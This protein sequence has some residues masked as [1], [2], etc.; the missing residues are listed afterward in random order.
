MGSSGPRRV[1]R[2]MRE[3]VL[4]TL[5]TQMMLGSISAIAGV[6]AH[7]S[8]ARGSTT[9]RSYSSWCAWNHSRESESLFMTRNSR[10]SSVKGKIPA[11]SRGHYNTYTLSVQRA[12]RLPAA[13][14][15][16]GCVLVLGGRQPIVVLR[17]CQP[18]FVLAGRSF[19]V[20]RAHRGL[21]ARQTR[22]AGWRPATRITLPTV[23]LA[24][25]NRIAL[26]TLRV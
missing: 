19:G 20:F 14:M 4:P 7:T 15:G 2:Q 11:S 6:R 16:A 1:S 26:C 17:P 23:L 5:G 3:I 8:S 10:V 18:P 9:R 22:P 12:T 21:P 25:K 24:P 13:Q